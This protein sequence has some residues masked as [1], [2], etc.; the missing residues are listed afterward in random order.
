VPRALWG[1]HCGVS[2]GDIEARPSIRL[3][4]LEG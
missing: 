3:L 1:F 2:V 4:G